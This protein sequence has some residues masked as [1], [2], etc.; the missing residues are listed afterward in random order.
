MSLVQ[1]GELTKLTTRDGTRG[2]EELHWR[3]RR[4]WLYTVDLG[5]VSKETFMC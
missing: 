1:K 4:D 5:E 3:V 2:R